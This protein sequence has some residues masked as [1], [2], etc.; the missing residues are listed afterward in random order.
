MLSRDRVLLIGDYVPSSNFRLMI[1]VKHARF[2]YNFL[3]FHGEAFNVI[4]LSIQLD[5]RSASFYISCCQDKH[6]YIRNA[7][8]ISI[9]SQTHSFS[10]FHYCLLSLFSA[11]LFSFK[12]V[13]P[14]NFKDALLANP[15][16]NFENGTFV[17]NSVTPS[18]SLPPQNDP[19]PH[20]FPEATVLDSLPQKD[21]FELSR[22]CLLGKMIYASLDL[23][24]II[25]R[26]KVHWKIIKGDVDYLEM[27]NG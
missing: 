25:V 23:R 13:I 20:S 3:N 17:P 5:E 2:S 19:H 14:S 18:S 24:T 11:S 4:E 7:L 1:L 10:H 22:S 8:V 16:P 27:G 15:N 6:S 9:Y 12:M 26:T 21:I